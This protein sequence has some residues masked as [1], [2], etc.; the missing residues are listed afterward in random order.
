MYKDNKKL[1][2]EDY[3]YMNSLSQAI[4]QIRPRKLHFILWFWFFTVLLFIVWASFTS[5]DEITRGTGE[6]VP[7]G[8]NQIVQNLEGGIVE[9]ILVKEG[10]VVK[11]DQILIKINNKK[12][13]STYET[14]NLKSEALKA[15]IIRLKAQAN[16][17]KFKYDKNVDKKVLDLYKNEESLFKSNLQQVKA[18]KDIL[19]NQ[20]IQKY[21]AIKDAKSQKATAA[22]SLSMINQELKML[23][24]MVKKGLSSNMDLLSLKREKNNI[25]QKYT[26]AKISIPRLQS[27]V[28][29]IKNKINEVD[30]I[31]QSKSK[32]ELSEALAQLHG[33]NASKDALKDQ[34]LRTD[35]RSPMNGIIQKL[36]V[37]T[38]SGVVKPAQDLVE[39]VPLDNQLILEVKIKPSDIAFIHE[40]IKA[41]VK[42]SAFDFS[43]YGGLEGKV[44]QMNPDTIK[45][46]EGNQFY[47]I[48][49]KTNTN[50]FKHNGK[51]MKIIPGMTVS[52]DILTGKKTVMDYILKPIIKAKQ[53]TFTER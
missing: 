15:K 12:S 8:E 53:Y 22:S 51:N 38:V 14:N 32:E 50:T 52:V 42:F 44:I 30:Y 43:I 24:P 16:N 1:T 3:E 46:K 23:S 2:Q 31:F 37:H 11:K 26:S 4:L 40:G 41:I 6:V 48:R 35:V 47:L 13:E 49:I 36:Y 10:Q 20:L 45:D 34:V 5:I 17:T 9:E 29:E 18:K 28:Q 19:K 7:S 21:N 33:T 25:S 39:I 27:E